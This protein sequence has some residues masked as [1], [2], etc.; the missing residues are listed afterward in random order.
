MGGLT[1]DDF[2]Q[3]VA[4][5]QIFGQGELQGREAGRQEGRQEGRQLGLRE[6][7]QEGRQ[8][9][10]CALLG[11]LLERRFGSLPA[12][13]KARLQGLPLESLEALSEALQDFQSSGDL[14]A[15]LATQEAV[16]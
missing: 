5:Q 14:Q 13:L 16:G 12:E 4:Y 9:E 6:G 10:A 2:T 1:L 11:R 3:S 15:W 7:R 8:Q